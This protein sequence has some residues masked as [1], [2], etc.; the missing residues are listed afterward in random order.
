MTEVKTHRDHPTTMSE[1][2]AK[3]LRNSG[4]P[5]A[6]IVTKTGDGP[7]RVFHNISHSGTADQHGPVHKGEGD[8]TGKPRGDV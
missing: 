5:N 6:D 3:R 2:I 7:T 8:I 1:R 4:D